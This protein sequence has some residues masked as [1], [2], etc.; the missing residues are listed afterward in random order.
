MTWVVGYNAILGYAFLVSDIQITVTAQDGT[1]SY[2]DCC[3]KI[4][5]LTE[6]IA[7]G[8][9]GSVKIGFEMI[10]ALQL[11]F[12]DKPHNTGWCLDEITASWLPEFLR[13]IFEI[14]S[15]E[16]KRQGC[17]IILVSAHPA[18]N[19]GDAPWPM[20]QVATFTSPIFE[21]KLEKGLRALSIG[22]GSEYYR[23]SI[24]KLSDSFNIMQSAMGGIGS[25]AMT[26]QHWVSTA[27]S[28]N[29]NLGIS[30]HY[31]LMSIERGKIVIYNTNYRIFNND[32]SIEE[33]I[34]PPVVT[35]YQALLEHLNDDG[36]AEISSITC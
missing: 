28:N 13:E 1:K 11:I 19:R 23:E 25:Y 30:S 5:P 32:D 34:T 24:E 12:S 31:Q 15:D 7:G 4:Y 33:R 22:S 16:E 14:S 27:F 29:P 3:Q 26:I 8:F 35:S 2:H 36:I 17:E 21:P 20:T 9:A 10:A 18:Q 6:W